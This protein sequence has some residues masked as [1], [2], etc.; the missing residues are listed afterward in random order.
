MIGKEGALPSLGDILAR[1]LP[2]VTFP[3]AAM[4]LLQILLNADG[5][6]MVKENLQ[7]APWHAGRGFSF[8]G[9]FSWF[10]FLVDE[11]EKLRG[12]HT[13]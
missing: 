10:S 2:E 6:T 11:G 3:K 9:T 12:N 4:S 13:F 7:T 1:R 8:L 5:T